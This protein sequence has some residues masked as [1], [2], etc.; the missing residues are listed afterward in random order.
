MTYLIHEDQQS[1]MWRLV[2][3]KH[4]NFDIMK[5]VVSYIISRKLKFPVKQ[6]LPLIIYT[7]TW[8]RFGI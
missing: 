5:S 8:K 4:E 3:N 2:Y 7:Y 6:Y 1:F